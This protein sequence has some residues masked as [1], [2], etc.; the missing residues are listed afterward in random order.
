[1]KSTPTVFKVIT[2]AAF[3]FLYVPIITLIVMSFNGGR[4]AYVMDGVSL[5]WYRELVSDGELIDALEQTLIVAA[6]SSS[7]AV[8][9]GTALAVGLAR[10][11]RSRTLE[12][13]SVAPAIIPDIV[14]GIGLAA[15]FTL[16]AIPLGV[17]TLIAGHTVFATAFVV[18]AVRARLATSDPSLEEASRDLGAG[19]FTTYL[20]IT[21]PIMAPAIIAGGL[22]AFTLSLDE[23]VMASFTTG[24]ASATLPILVYS[25][26]RFNLTPEI[27][28]LGTLLVVVSLVALVIGARWIGRRDKAGA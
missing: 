3:I 15:M 10:T 28:A 2:V 22:L 1:M 4:N 19:A 17:T 7:I 5:Q 16:L 11:T 6:V 9:L 12:V 21:T 25:R 8:V 23:Y 26:V 13:V 14:Q 24:S 20:R 18:S 27:N